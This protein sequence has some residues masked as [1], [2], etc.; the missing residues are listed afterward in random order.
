M[1]L[2]LLAPD[3]LIE[4]LALELGIAKVGQQVLK[5]RMFK[6]SHRMIT[7]AQPKRAE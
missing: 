5:M 6:T 7:P 1:G 2:P 3:V 4:M